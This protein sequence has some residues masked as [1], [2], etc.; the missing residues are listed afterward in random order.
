M[1]AT[2]FDRRHDFAAGGCMVAWP[3]DRSSV[4][5]RGGELERQIGST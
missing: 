2:I 3:Y 1:L 4:Y 5:Y